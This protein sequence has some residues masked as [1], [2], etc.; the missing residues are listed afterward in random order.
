[1]RE[2]AT[3]VPGSQHE[4]LSGPLG[5]NDNP[6]MFFSWVFLATVFRCL[7]SNPIRHF[8]VMDSPWILSAKTWA[9]PMGAVLDVTISLSIWQSSCLARWKIRTGGL[10]A[11]DPSPVAAPPRRLPAENTGMGRTGVYRMPIRS[12]NQSPTKTPYVTPTQDDV[13]FV[14]L[15]AEPDGLVGDDLLDYCLEGREEHEEDRQGGQPVPVLERHGWLG[16]AGVTGLGEATAVR[17]L[18]FRWSLLRRCRRL[19]LAAWQGR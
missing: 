12:A 7:N 2:K 6:K 1:M 8:D 18:A 10:R 14:R 9:A 3:T 4:G 19:A 11:R 16:V 5:P 15:D 13:V 17:A